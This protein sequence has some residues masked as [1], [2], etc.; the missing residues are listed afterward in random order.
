MIIWLTVVTET[1][2]G[3]MTGQIKKVAAIYISLPYKVS[4]IFPKQAYS[5]KKENS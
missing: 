1:Y 4:I 3:C 2:L 5:L